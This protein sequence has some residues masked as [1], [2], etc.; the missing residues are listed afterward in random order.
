VFSV[1]EDRAFRAGIKNSKAAKRRA[2]TLM[3]L[4]VF[5]K[6]QKRIVE[7]FEENLMKM[8]VGMLDHYNVS[9]RK[10]DETV[11][12]YENVLGFTNGPRP[13]FNFPGASLYCSGH[14]VLHLNDISQTGKQQQS[15]SGVID[16]VAFSRRGFEATKQHLSAKGVR[17][18]SR[19]PTTGVGKETTAT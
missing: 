12:F 14:P 17:Y 3:P 16:H 13:P 2:Q 4:G 10:L 11:H 5:V 1:Y 19:I 6:S 8:S 18:V 15:D 7:T 9:T